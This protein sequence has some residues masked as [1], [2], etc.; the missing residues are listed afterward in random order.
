MVN[1]KAS[2]FLFIFVSSNIK[3]AVLLQ[4]EKDFSNARYC[5]NTFWPYLY[6]EIF[7][8]RTNM[9]SFDSNLWIIYGGMPQRWKIVFNSIWET[10]VICLCNL[11]LVWN[12]NRSWCVN[13]YF[14]ITLNGLIIVTHT[15]KLL[16]RLKKFL[17]QCIY[18]TKEIG[19]YKFNG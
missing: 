11:F 2:I 1:F 18:F 9:R 15:E 4:T 16:D 19:R 5:N 12:N 14:D 7:I 10:H 6:T 13:K 17:F 8:V 3:L